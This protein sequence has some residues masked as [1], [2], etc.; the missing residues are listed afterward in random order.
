MFNRAPKS[1]GSS[2]DAGRPA[3]GPRKTTSDTASVIGADLVITGNLDAKGESRVDGQVE[4]DIHAQRIV[5]GDGA[6]TTGNLVA[7]SIEVQGT[8]QGSIRG[9]AVT[10]TSSSRVEA[11]VSHKSLTVE[12]GAFFEGKS[13]RSEN[14]MSVQ[15]SI[16]AVLPTN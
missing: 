10:F 1:H 9:N 5:I 2:V 15:R 4:G 12:Q 11:D 13:R 6:R 3:S 14:P 16:N 7:E 8:A